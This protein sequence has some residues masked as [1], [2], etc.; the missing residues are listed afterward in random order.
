MSADVD[1]AMEEYFESMPVL[2]TLGL[3]EA[4]IDS[5]EV[6][7]R[8]PYSDSITN[9]T[10]VHGGVLATLVDATIAGSIHSKAEAT[11]DEMEPLT[12]DLDINYIAPVREG[13]IVAQSELISLGSTIAVGWC[14]IYNESDLVACGT[15]TYFQ[16]WKNQ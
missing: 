10:V 14:E 12:I 13:E 7:F 16:R 9:H 5:G 3:E 2:D 6:E 1:A 11:L 8:L 15:A 4:T